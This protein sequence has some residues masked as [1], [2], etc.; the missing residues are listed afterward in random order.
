MSAAKSRSLARVDPE[1]ARA[2][3]GS[4]SYAFI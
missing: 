2:V 4:C 1:L 3:L